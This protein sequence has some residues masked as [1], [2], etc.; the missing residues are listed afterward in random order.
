MP[1]CNGGS[2][3]LCSQ[4]I[5]VLAFV[6]TVAHGMRGVSFLRVFACNA[7]GL[8]A[9]QV[10]PKRTAEGSALA[11]LNYTHTAFTHAWEKG[12]AASSPFHVG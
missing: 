4:L 8:C 1:P 3:K 9:L 2:R 10:F 7:L 12:A 5:L 6:G 11:G